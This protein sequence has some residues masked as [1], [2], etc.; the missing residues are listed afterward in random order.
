PAIDD[1]AAVEPAVDW[2]I[3]LRAWAERALASGETGIHATAN[4][5]FERVLLETALAAEHGHRQNA[6]KVLGLGRNTITRK[7]GS[8]RRKP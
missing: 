4:A 5:A 3:G 8:S 6:A 7:L 2:T 1:A